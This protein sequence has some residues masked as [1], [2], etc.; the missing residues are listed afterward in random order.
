MSDESTQDRRPLAVDRILPAYEQVAAQLR[1]Q[2][3]AG[4]LSPGSR[5]PA[6][7]ELASMFG[8]SRS[9]VREALRLL[10]SQGLAVTKRGVAGGTFVA[11]VEPAQLIAYLE[12]VLRMFSGS[13][14][15]SL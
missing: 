11:S 9:T 1:A 5:L 12:T 15:L 8:V 6:E 4:S 14:A 2:I 7:G 10:T 3:V 13:Q